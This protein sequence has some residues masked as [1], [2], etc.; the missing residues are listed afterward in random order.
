[1]GRPL[2]IFD[3]TGGVLVPDKPKTNVLDGFRPVRV[4][5]AAEIND[6]GPGHVFFNLPTLEDRQ[7][8]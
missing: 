5:T 1:M 4:G 7:N 2:S 6:S 3:Q 8:E